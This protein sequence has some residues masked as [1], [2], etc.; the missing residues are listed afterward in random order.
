MNEQIKQILLLTIS[1]IGMF[2]YICWLC[3]SNRTN[4][5]NGG[6]VRNIKVDNYFVNSMLCVS[7]STI[8]ILLG[9]GLKSNIE[10]INLII[11]VVNVILFIIFKLIKVKTGIIVGRFQPF[12]TGHLY[13]IK[14]ILKYVDKLYICIGSYDKYGTDRNPLRGEMRYLIL[15]NAL[16]KYIDKGKVVLVPID[17]LKGEENDNVDWGD[18]LI[19]K[20][21]EHSKTVPNYIFSGEESVRNNWFSEDMLSHISVINIPKTPISATQVRD[22][23]NKGDS[24]D[25]LEYLPYDEALQKQVISEIKK[26]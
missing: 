9:M 5:L 11:Y 4:N 8:F 2:I 26:V 22:A 7:L 24:E 23:I 19:D 18:Y 15:E 6:R 3:I 12:H 20:V 16:K 25:I 1:I 21:K 14:Y 10:I 17:D 13:I